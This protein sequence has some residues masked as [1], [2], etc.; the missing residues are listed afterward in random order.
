MR[1]A[2]RSGRCAID[3]AIDPAAN[4]R[5]ERSRLVVAPAARPGWTRVTLPVVA[6]SPGTVVTMTVRGAREVCVLGAGEPGCTTGSPT[7]WSVPSLPAAEPVVVEVRHDALAWIGFALE[8]LDRP[9]DVPADNQV[10]AIL[11]PAG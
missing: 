11:R 3:P 7:G 9:D 4:P 5:F 8:A 1:P 6:T 10:D 2:G